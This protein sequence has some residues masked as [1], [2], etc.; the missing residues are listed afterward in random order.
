MGLVGQGL[1]IIGHHISSER[2]KALRDSGIPILIITGT[3]DKLVKPS[4]SYLLKKSL[5]PEQFIILEGAGHMVHRE[6]HQ[7]VNKA[8]HEHFLLHNNRIR[9][10]L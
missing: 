8:M 10:S 3:K 7:I 2:L 1:A 6:S 4:N 5:E 9:A